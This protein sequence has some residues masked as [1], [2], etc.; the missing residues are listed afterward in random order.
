MLGVNE[1]TRKIEFLGGMG[2]CCWSLDA[3]VKW[4][5]KRTTIHQVDPT[6]LLAFNDRGDGKGNI[7]ITW[8]VV[9]QRGITATDFCPIRS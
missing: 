8:R 9:E 5:K 3:L 6:L 7:I 1:W 2:V 4:I